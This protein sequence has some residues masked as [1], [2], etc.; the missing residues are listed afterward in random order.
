MTSKRLTHK[1]THT[2]ICSKNREK[3]KTVNEAVR[4]KSKCVKRL[5][6]K[7]RFLKQKFVNIQN[8]TQTYCLDCKNALIIYVQN[9]KIMKNEEIKGE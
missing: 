8:I 1:H 7:S 3:N 2:H 6:A 4:E 9:K 5:S